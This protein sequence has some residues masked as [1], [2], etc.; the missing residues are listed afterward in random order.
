MRP[1]PSR[2]RREFAAT[3]VTRSQRIGRQV[4]QVNEPVI[5]HFVPQVYLLKF[6]AGKGIIVYDVSKRP[7]AI[8]RIIGLRLE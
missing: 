1:C 3:R 5:Q 7:G 8:T 4:D 6:D 2:T